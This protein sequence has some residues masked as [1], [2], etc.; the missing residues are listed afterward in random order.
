MLAQPIV[1]VMLDIFDLSGRT[2]FITGAGRGIGR[3]SAMLLARAGADVALA[4]R[5]PAELETV[6]EDVRSLGR[7]ASVH[8]L[9]VHDIPDIAR[10]VERIEQLH[11]RIDILVNNAG[12]NVQRAA[13]EV[14]EADWD[15]VMDTNAKGAFFCAQAVGRGM[16]KRG[17]GKIINMASTF[18]MLGFPNR[19]A[20]AASKGAVIQFTRVM[21]VEWAELGVNVNAIG[22]TAT[23]TKM[24]AD[25]F[26]DE[27]WRAAVLPRI[28]AGR[29]AEPR[30]VAGAVLYLASSASD[31]VN[32]HL[33]LVDG[34]W[35]AI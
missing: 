17:S 10:T 13:L 15:L 5:S 6:A 29:F 16:V 30:D 21:A 1:G 23:E 9:D 27:T 33:L 20:Y 4:S 14:T 3:E 31:M 12:T 8:A 28:P 2:A 7:R 18:A 25:L 22:P 34:G 35:S 26:R 19:T 32:G 11:G 24:N